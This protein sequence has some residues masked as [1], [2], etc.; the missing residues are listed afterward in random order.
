MF[1]KKI[2]SV[3]VII[4]V[5]IFLANSNSKQKVFWPDFLKFENEF[6]IKTDKEILLS[7][8]DKKVGSVESKSPR[9]TCK[10]VPLNNEASNLPVGT[11]IYSLASIIQTGIVVYCNEK[12]IYYE[13]V[14]EDEFYNI[15]SEYDTR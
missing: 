2:M 8:V 3:I 15:V 12:Y 1:L 9:N 13:K 5:V 10:W 11:E 7:N 6:Y 4:I 14:T